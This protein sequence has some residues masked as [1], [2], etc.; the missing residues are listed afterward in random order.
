[1]T[2]NSKVQLTQSQ[3]EQGKSTPAIPIRLERVPRLAHSLGH[4]PIL[5]PTS[6]AAHISQEG[7]G[8]DSI[9]IQDGMNRPPITST[10]SDS[11]VQCFLERDTDGNWVENGE[12][13]VG[14]EGILDAARGMWVSPTSAA[15][16]SANLT[17]PLH[18]G[19]ST[20]PA[21][22]TTG[23]D[24][25]GYDDPGNMEFLQELGSSNWMRSVEANKSIQ[26]VRDELDRLKNLEQSDAEESDTEVAENN[27]TSPIYRVNDVYDVMKVKRQKLDKTQVG[28]KVY[29]RMGGG[30]VFEFKHNSPNNFFFTPIPPQGKK[31]LRTPSGGEGVG[32]MESTSGSYKGITSKLD[33]SRSK[34]IGK[35][36]RKKYTR[37]KPYPQ[38]RNY[39]QEEQN[40]MDELAA[41]LYIA[42]GARTEFGYPLATA[43]LQ[44]M[45]QGVS[46]EDVFYK[47]T[48]QSEALHVGTSNVKVSGI[49]GQLMEQNIG[50]GT[51]DPHPFTSK[52]N[53]STK[54]YE[55]GLLRTQRL[56]Q[57]A[58]GSRPF[59]Q[60]FSEDFA[61]PIREEQERR[62]AKRG[63][64]SNQGIGVVN[65]PPDEFA[66]WEQ[67]YRQYEGAPGATAPPVVNS[68]DASVES[69]EPG[70][71][72]EDIWVKIKDGS[73]APELDSKV[74]YK[75]VVYK[76]VQNTT[77]GYL[78]QKDE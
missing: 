60:W 59:G 57:T 22:Q 1:M 28:G 3:I 12:D 39:T 44:N 51:N 15:T 75:G 77:A 58:S 32:Y 26:Q 73:Q 45:E 62:V 10:P 2:R 18:G 63:A 36:I 14:V 53:I 41:A 55:E 76:V 49:S 70:S 65:L 72:T 35:D 46:M 6:N 50:K 66:E 78:L 71:N 7:K 43:S 64:A 38:K 21:H 27:M 16:G 69:S 68:I 67:L 48:G 54:D 4:I 11:V 23:I 20:D 31:R 8:Y 30:P 52:K 25:S 29:A 17:D 42:E 13:P 56:F 9:S 47:G 34:Q 5:P 24:F 33:S 74:Q 37:K 61:Q 19:T 40:T